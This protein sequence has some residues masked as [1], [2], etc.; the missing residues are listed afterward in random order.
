MS[1]EL[2]MTVR[3]LQP[4]AQGMPVELYFFSA[5]TAWLKYESLQAEVFE[6]ILAMLHTFGLKVFQSPSGTDIKNFQQ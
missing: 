4:T 5:D 6:H 2:T 1:K 3:L